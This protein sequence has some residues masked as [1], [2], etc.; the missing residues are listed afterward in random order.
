MSG[1]IYRSGGGRF[2]NHIFRFLASRLFCMFYN[3]EIVN[4]PLPNRLIITD[5][6]FSDWANILL[7]N[8]LIEYPINNFEFNGYYQHDHIYIKYK[9]QFLDYINSNKEYILSMDNP[10]IN[11]LNGAVLEAPSKNINI[12]LQD[13]I[14]I[15]PV[16]E[17]K[18]NTAIH[19]RIED[20]LHIGLGMNPLSID[21][22]LEKCER[23]FIFVHKPIYN[24]LDTKYIQYFKT[25]YPDAFFYDG[26]LIDCYNILR[27]SKILVCSQSTLSWIA[28]FFNEIHTKIY[29]PR[30]PQNCSH[31]TF[32]YPSD[33]TEIYNYENLS[34]QQLN[35]LVE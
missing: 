17:F 23:P 34:P 18:Y 32:Q 4:T 30:N 24:E 11:I 28:A 14:G 15:P 9:Q 27:N 2:G 22:V 21:F 20:F 33:K 6:L 35:M 10:D 16:L 7:N 25:K 8:S 19:L 1:F 3:C 12:Q 5:E 31:Q 26:D 29:M 13:L